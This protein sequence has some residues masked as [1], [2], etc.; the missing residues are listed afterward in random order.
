MGHYAKVST[1]TDGKGLVEQV[2][3]ADEEFIQSGLVGDPFQW[4]K[5]SY[6]TRGGVHYE[7][8]SQNPSP[9]QTKALRANFAQVGDI[10]DA[11]NDVF[12]AQRRYP[13]W[14][15]GAP[16]WQW[17]APVP[18][19]KDGKRYDWDETNLNWKEIVLPAV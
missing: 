6:N 13:S 19:P 10:Y 17:E 3:V 5:T 1:I 12:Y 7:T 9:D 8:D 11:V 15:I 16:T 2:I 18:R 4:I 14:S